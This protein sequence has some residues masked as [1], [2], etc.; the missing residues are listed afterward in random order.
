MALAGRAIMAYLRTESRGWKS[1]LPTWEG[2][3]L[4][5]WLL[6]VYGLS[7]VFCILLWAGLS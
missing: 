6:M 4:L 2:L 7:W 5:P 3:L 1:I